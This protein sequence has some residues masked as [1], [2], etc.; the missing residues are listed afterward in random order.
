MREIGTLK[1]LDEKKSKNDHDT[2]NILKKGRMTKRGRPHPFPSRITRI[3]IT[4][5]NVT[6][7]E[8]TRNWKILGEGMGRNPN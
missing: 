2:S 5:S 7:Q 4:G 1:K 6:M 3:W 8:I